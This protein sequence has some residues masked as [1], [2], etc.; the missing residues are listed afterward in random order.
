M[1]TKTL[2]NLIE[3]IKTNSAW[4]N[5]I[6]NYMFELVENI[7]N[8]KN[9]INKNLKDLSINELKEIC[10]NGATN[11]SQYSWGGCSLVYNYDILENLFPKS[12]V[13]KYK[14]SDSIKGTHLLEYQA[15][16]LHRAFCK[17]YSIIKNN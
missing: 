6:K 16:A 4:S 15:M 17:I 14:N 2:I 11:W 5:G 10:L 7:E 8:H 9:Y 1:N 3:K 12:I 13:K